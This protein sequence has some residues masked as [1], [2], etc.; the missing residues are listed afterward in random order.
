MIYYSY[1]RILSYNAFLNFLIGERGVG[2]T[3]G[4]VKFCI[5]KFLKKGEQFIYLRRYKSDLKKSVP[6][7]FD[8]MIKNNEFPEATFKTSGA[9]F[10]INDKLAR[11]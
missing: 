4:A 11:L 10:Y 8:A 9:N 7:F 3:Y 6:T 2:K 5:Q 1:Q